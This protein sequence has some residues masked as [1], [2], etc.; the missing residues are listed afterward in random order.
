MSPL[1][2]TVTVFTKGKEIRVYQGPVELLELEPGWKQYD[3]VPLQDARREA[4]ARGN[5][6]R[7][8]RRGRP[9]EPGRSGEA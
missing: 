6:G 9:E 8:R 1:L 4:R 2:R 3:E 5:K 7:G